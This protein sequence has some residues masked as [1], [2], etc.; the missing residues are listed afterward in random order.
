MDKHLDIARKA[1][2][3]ASKK[4]MEFYGAQNVKVKIKG[5]FGPVTEADHAANEIICTMLHKEFPEYGILTEEEI[6]NPELQHALK[7]WR[8]TEYTWFIDPLDGTDPFIHMTGE[9]GIHIGLTH[10]GIPIMG[11]NTYPVQGI[12]YWAVKGKG[13]FKESKGKQEKIKVSGIANIAN[14]RVFTDPF[15]PIKAVEEL[16]TRIPH[17][18]V[19]D[20]GSLG[21]R[22]CKVAESEGDALIRPP[23]NSKTHL[24][25]VCSGHVIITEAGGMI[26]DFFGKPID[27]RPKE[28]VLSKG[29]IITNGKLHASLLE[30]TRI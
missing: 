9:F 13:A 4:I 8:E 3:A 12:T 20:V 6:H 1:A 23:I 27:Y 14:M 22:I 24:W 29:Y 5:E 16:L 30:Q 15:Y 17:S 18:T 7:H 21:L 26:T 11:L 10:K 25:D 2:D 19:R 28:Y